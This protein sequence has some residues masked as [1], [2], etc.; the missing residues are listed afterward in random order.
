MNKQ[1]NKEMNLH[2]REI[3]LNFD[4]NRREREKNQGRKQVAATT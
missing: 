2:E 4:E 3:R 1:V